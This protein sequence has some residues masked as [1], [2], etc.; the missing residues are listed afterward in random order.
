[1]API[2]V[3]CAGENTPWETYCEDPDG[4]ADWLSKKIAGS[5]QIEHTATIMSINFCLAIPTRM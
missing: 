5:A 2:T 4:C 1:M 3:E